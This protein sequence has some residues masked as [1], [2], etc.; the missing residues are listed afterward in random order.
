MDLHD[1]RIKG[2]VL[3]YQ[4]NVPGYGN[5]ARFAFRDLRD[6]IFD[7]PGA[8]KHCRLMIHAPDIPMHGYLTAGVSLSSQAILF[9]LFGIGSASRQN[10]M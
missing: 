9:A 10:G 4:K 3:T 1:R 8:G 2:D 7:S 5:T 6:Q